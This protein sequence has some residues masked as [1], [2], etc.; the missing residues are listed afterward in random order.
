M[1]P[2]TKIKQPCLHPARLI[3]CWLSHT[4]TFLERHKSRDKNFSCLGFG[5]N[6]RLVADKVSPD[7]RVRADHMRFEKRIRI[8]P[9]VDRE[10]RHR[11]SH[12]SVWKKISKRRM[13]T[14]KNC[15]NEIAEKRTSLTR[16][17]SNICSFPGSY[18][19]LSP[20]LPVRP[21]SRSHGHLTRELLSS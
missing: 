14:E 13:R 8:E 17:I 16:I 3:C 15:V 1:H 20:S 11:P 5:I 4:A 19:Y 21:D 10:Q 18:S 12:K 6:H 7:I 2:N 9:G